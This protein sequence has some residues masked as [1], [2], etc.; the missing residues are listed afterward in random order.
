MV[1][2]K[3]SCQCF[4]HSVSGSIVLFTVV[5]SLI[6]SLLSFLVPSSFG[7]SSN[8]LLLLL[9]SSLQVSWF[10]ISSDKGNTGQVLDHYLYWRERG[11]MEIR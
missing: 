11:L 3:S 5:S 7:C 6:V 10:G 9:L 1:C 4:L 8:Y 2:S